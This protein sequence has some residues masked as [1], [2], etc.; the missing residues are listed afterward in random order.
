MTLALPRRLTGPVTISGDPWLPA[1]AVLPTFLLAFVTLLLTCDDR[2]VALFWPA[3]AVILALLL[4]TAA[5][6]WWRTLAAGALGF[7]LAGIID[8]DQSVTS[9]LLSASNLLEAALSAVLIRCAIRA[10]IDLSRPNHLA[11]LFA[12]TAGAPAG[13][14]L[15]AALLLSDR[16]GE[17]FGHTFGT[18]YLGDAAGLVLLTP[19]LLLASR[20][21]LQRE[22]A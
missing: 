15:C 18:W 21:F 2:R 11:A 12:A 3:N 13:S 6:D 5:R 10:E 16:R 19:L 9:A 1:A 7:F 8:G 22:R 20:V 4:Q 14:A 17:P